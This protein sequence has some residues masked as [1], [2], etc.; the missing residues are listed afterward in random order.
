MNNGNYDNF[1]GNDYNDNNGGIDID[2]YNYCN[3]IACYDICL[4]CEN[5]NDGWDDGGK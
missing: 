4:D 5:D 1:F 2:W 3:D